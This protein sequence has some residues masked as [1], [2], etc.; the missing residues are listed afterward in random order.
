M[1]QEPPDLMAQGELRLL[2]AQLEY[3]LLG[4]D[5]QRR[6]R[7]VHGTPDPIG[8]GRQGPRLV[9]RRGAFGLGDAVQGR[10]LGRDEIR[11]PRM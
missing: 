3:D 7:R 11:R 1:A 5:L 6:R 2:A 8:Q 10:G 4:A 9:H